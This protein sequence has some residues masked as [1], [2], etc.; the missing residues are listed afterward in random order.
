MSSGRRGPVLSAGFLG[1]AL[2]L[3]PAD[4]A[5]AQ[6]PVQLLPGR[7]PQGGKHSIWQQSLSA[8]QVRELLARYGLGDKSADNFLEDLIRKAVRDRNPKA[9]DKQVND[10]IKRLLGDKDFMDRMKDLAQKHK[11]QNRDPGELPKLTPEDLARL[12]NLRPDA[13]NGD[14]FKLPKFDPDQPP[15]IGPNWLPKFDPKQLPNIDPGTGFPLDP[16]TGKP[17]DPRTGKPID[18]NNPPKFEHP[19]PPPKAE[20][21]P[22]PGPNAPLPADPPAEPNRKF[23]PNNPLGPVEESPENKIRARAAETATALWEKNV[24]PIDESPAVKRAILD[25]V[26]DPEAMD[27]LTDGKGNSIF[28]M[29]RDAD[30]EGLKDLFAGIDGKGWEWPKLDF[31]FNFNWGNSRNIDLPDAPRRQRPDYSADR[32]G[33]SW[34]DKW[35][36]IGGL[37]VPWVPVLLLLG[38]VVA[39]VLW[40]KWAALFPAAD[41]VR[42]AAGGLGPWPVDPRS[43]GTREDVVKAFEHLSVLICGP[44]AKTWTHSTIAGELTA[45][46]ATH[47]ETAVKL[48]RLYELARYAP[49][50]EPLTRAELVEARRLVCDL[51]GV[52]E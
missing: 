27:A 41:R 26:S 18:P 43:I 10:A 40:W 7:D 33:F 30:G 32:R 1:L 37:R 5:L 29:F 4:R 45:L 14:P 35:L 25:L 31:N 50:D 49:L 22:G 6:P 12:K 52:D 36:D 21:P 44:A 51:A 42:Y 3:C 15:E 38:A 46:A 28:D 48:A 16:R 47:G 2:W 34:G 19:P 23:D 13:G 39:A 8:E 11:N 20:N 17:F 9:D 24:G